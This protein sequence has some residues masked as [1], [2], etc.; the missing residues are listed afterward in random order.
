MTSGKLLGSLR[1]MGRPVSAIAVHSDG[2][3]AIHNSTNAL[4]HVCKRQRTLMIRHQTF[5]YVHFWSRNLLSSSKPT[6]L[7]QSGRSHC[8]SARFYF[9]IPRQIRHSVKSN[10][11]DLDS[12]KT[13]IYLN[14]HHPQKLTHIPAMDTSEANPEQGGRQTL[15]GHPDDQALRRYHPPSSFVHR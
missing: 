2:V 5:L 9:H 8:Q 12:T 15:R 4:L 13:E 3:R 11:R 10:P 14:L 1:R 6:S 7:V